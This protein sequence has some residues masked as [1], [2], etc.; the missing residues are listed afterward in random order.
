M[1]NAVK[2]QIAGAMALLG[3]GLIVA[4]CKSAPPLSQTQ[5]QS[6]IQAKYDQAAPAPVTI[7]LRND[8]MVEGV[9]D[10]YWD[11]TK[12]YPNGLWADF[13]LTPDGKKLISVPGGGDVIQ[14]RPMT[15]GDKRYS[16]S[17]ATVT[18]TRFKATN[19]RNIQSEMLPGASKA[20]GCDY[21]EIVDFTG[22]PAPLADLGHDPGNQISFTR[23][24]DF[25][26]VNSAWVLKS[27]E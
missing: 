3:A 26:L 1:K 17:V 12:V 14:W 8:G 5:A 18:A 24:A 11:R 2:L 23:H 4:G 22:I 27:T 16:V 13:T 25:A 7:T 10:K 9:T 19:I 6:M 21:D 15:V 20:M